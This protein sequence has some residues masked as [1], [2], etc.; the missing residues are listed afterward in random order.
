MINA[1]IGTINS[2]KHFIGNHEV[3]VIAEAFG[4]NY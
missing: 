4:N 1:F 2:R 3:Y